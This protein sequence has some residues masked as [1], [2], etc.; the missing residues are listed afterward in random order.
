VASSSSPPSQGEKKGGSESSTSIHFER[1]KAL[2][3]RA[4][5][6]AEGEAVGGMT[7]PHHS[8]KKKKSTIDSSKDGVEMGKMT[9]RPRSSSSTFSSPSSAY[10]MRSQSLNASSSMT[11]YD[12]SSPGY[13]GEE[14]ESPESKV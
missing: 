6:G 5:G 8:K 11:P 2:A 3:A 7:A 10:A 13:S 9:T 1:D 14:T 12:T 4:A